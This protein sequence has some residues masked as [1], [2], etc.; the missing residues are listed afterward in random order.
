MR[1]ILKIMN[2]TEQYVLSFDFDKILLIV[3]LKYVKLL[4]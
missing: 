3:K 1:N 2:R 4:N